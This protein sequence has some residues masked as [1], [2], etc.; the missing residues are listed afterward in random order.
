MVSILPNE[1]TNKS[2]NKISYTFDSNDNNEISFDSRET[3]LKE[4]IFETQGRIHFKNFVLKTDTNDGNIKNKKFDVKEKIVKS[5]LKIN[6]E[7][8]NED[9]H[10]VLFR[11]N[12]NINN[13]KNNKYN[14]Y[15]NAI[16]LI[17]HK[18]LHRKNMINDK[19]IKECLFFND[20]ANSK[21]EFNLEGEENIKYDQLDQFIHKLSKT[22]KN[23]EY[24]PIKSIILSI[25]YLMN[26]L[27]INYNKMKN[28]EKNIFENIYNDFV[29]KSNLCSSE[30]EEYFMLSFEGFRIK[31]Q[32]NFTLS[33]LFTDIFWNY[34]FHNDKFRNL[35][36]NSYLEESNENINIDSDKN[37]YLKK[38]I[39]TIY[40]INN[41]LMSQIVELL[42]IYK[43]DENDDLM[44]I[45]VK[46]KNRYHSE[47]IKSEKEK[48]KEKE[49]EN[50]N[51]INIEE[52]QNNTNINLPKNEK[53]ITYNIITAN[54]ISVIKY[55]KQKVN[56]INI[57][58]ENNIEKEENNKLIKNDT[59][60]NDDLEHKSVEEI[61]NYINDNKIIKN[62][63]KKRSRKNK[64][65]KIKEEINK[66][67]G[68]ETEDEIVVKFKEDLSDKLF[69]AGS[70]TK[71]KPVLSEQWIK[72]I[73]T[74]D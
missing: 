45:I 29:L 71:I 61:Y 62:K 32:I 49:K 4:S 66:E 74:Y 3:I 27:I 70:I 65:S 58:K 20:L 42:N 22:D 47:I 54:D 52:K 30:L 73:S 12:L 63:K 2:N 7:N 5:I 48:E 8:G 14:K 19:K 38:I 69:H 17:V 34:I 10:I 13:D 33:E 15:F 36:I 31:Y 26:E 11:N 37:E 67:V 57:S 18:T 46:E 59:D 43:I 68:K 1:K 35:L 41:P 53:N 39:K 55:K 6:V 21:Q 60:N 25:L 9:Q 72:K 28:D 44:S 50:Y 64:K 23:F 24:F 40:N 16:N 56:N 51:R